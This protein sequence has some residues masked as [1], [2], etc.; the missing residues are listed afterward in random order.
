MTQTTRRA[1]IVNKQTSPRNNTQRNRLLITGYTAK[2]AP[3]QTL[4]TF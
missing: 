1:I 4:Q 3:D 2:D